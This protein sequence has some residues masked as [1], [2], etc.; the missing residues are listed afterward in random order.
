MKYKLTD[1]DDIHAVAGAPGAAAAA[2]DAAAAAHDPVPHVPLELVTLA[3]YAC[4]I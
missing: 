1:Q 2:A 3:E 4:S